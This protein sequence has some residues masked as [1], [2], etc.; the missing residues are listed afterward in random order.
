MY[1]SFSARRKRLR[2]VV[3]VTAATLPVVGSVVTPAAATC[4]VTEA[5]AR[6]E[7]A[8]AIP[9]VARRG[10]LGYWRR[11]TSGRRESR[12]RYSRTGC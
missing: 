10:N 9:K 2:V 8:E 12:H 5:L 4:R 7:S 3:L 1:A 6:A 11:S